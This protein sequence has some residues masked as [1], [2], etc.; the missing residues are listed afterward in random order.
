MAVYR[1]GFFWKVVERLNKCSSG[2]SIGWGILVKVR[3][4]NSEN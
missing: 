3:A 4:M 2:G 1:H